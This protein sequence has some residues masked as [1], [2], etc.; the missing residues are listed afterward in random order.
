[1]AKTAFQLKFKANDKGKEYKFEEIQ[2]SII[3]IRDTQ[4]YL[5]EL[6]YLVL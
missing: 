4:G 1:M 2:D 5:S 3:H 6:Y